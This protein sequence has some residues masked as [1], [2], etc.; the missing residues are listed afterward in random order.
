MTFYEQ[1][2]ITLVDK[3]VIGLIVLIAWYLVNR[4]LES[5]K[6]DRNIEIETFKQQQTRDLEDFKSQQIRELEEFK[7]NKARELEEFK[8]VRALENEVKKLREGKH[9]EYREKQLS[10]FYWAIYMRLSM[11]N[12][13]W[14]KIL[15][16]R[17]DNKELRSIAENIE[18]K[19]VLP[20]HDEIVRILETNIHLMEDDANLLIA[21]KKYLRHISVYKAL[22]SAGIKDKF[23][24]DYDEPYPTDFF[25]LIS[26]HAY[27]IQAEYDK[28]IGTENLKK[29]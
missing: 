27:K 14:K 15:D 28:L 3:F 24:F 1:L 13:I 26:K 16:K 12:V 8:S 7:S 5:F 10:H 18:E 23:P 22:R 6:R 4:F 20:N 19:M 17:N 2:L 11:D 29:L 9:L 25:D 21:I